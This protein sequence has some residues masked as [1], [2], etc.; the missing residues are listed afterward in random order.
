MTENFCAFGN[1][2][3]VYMDIKSRCTVTTVPPFDV[4]YI[5]KSCLKY[6][7]LPKNSH[8]LLYGNKFF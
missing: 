1:L 4:Y 8:L 5:L 7:A 6:E 2:G 3:A